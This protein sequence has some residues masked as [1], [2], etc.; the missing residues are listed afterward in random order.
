MKNLILAM[1]GILITIYTLLISLDVVAVQICQNRLERTLSHTLKNILEQDYQDASDAM[2]EQRI[3][4]GVTAAMGQDTSLAIEIPVIDMQRGIISVQ[5]SKEVS[6]FSGKSKTVSCEKTVIMEQR[7]PEVTQ[8]VTVTFYVGENF[9][10]EYRI[11]KGRG[12]PM[13]KLPT[14]N[15]IGWR[16]R[17]A[18]AAGAV[19]EIREVWEDCE[20]EAMEE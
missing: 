8:M 1:L 9:Y 20:Y 14:G 13:P 2:T 3:I 17:S 10:K 11:E 15:Y 19:T 12:C 18:P 4:S 7:K 16:A 5:V 6:R